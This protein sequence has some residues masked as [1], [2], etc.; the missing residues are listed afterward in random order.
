MSALEHPADVREWLNRALDDARWAQYSFEG[1]FLP[2][3]CFACQQ[4]VEKALKAF[5][6]VN[7]AELRRIHS[8]PDLLRDAAQFDAEATQFDD[9][10]LVLDAYYSPTRYADTLVELDYTEARVQDALERTRLML[11]WLRQ[12]IEAQLADSNS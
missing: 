10:A 12:R 2:Q 11:E 7:G 1:E 5:L 8:L 9:S 4:A 6:L 3:A